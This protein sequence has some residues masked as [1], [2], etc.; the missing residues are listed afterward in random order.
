MKNVTLFFL[1]LLL[2]IMPGWNTV[3]AQTIADTLVMNNENVLVGEIKEMTHGVLQMKTKYSDSDLKLKWDHIKQ[4]HT[5][6]FFII[7][8][9]KGIH[10]Y[11]TLNTKKN[12]PGKIYLFDFQKGEALVPQGKIIYLKEA[13]QTFISRLSLDISLGYSLAKANNTSQFITRVNSGYLANVY[14]VR[15]NYSMNRNFQTVDDTLKTKIRRTEANFAGKYFLKKSWFLTGSANLLSSTEQKLNLRTTTLFGVGNFLINDHVHY[16]SISGGGVWNIERY[17][18]NDQPDKNSLEAF[19]NIEYVLF[20][21]GDL[22]IN[23]NLDIY[24][25]ITEKGRLRS[26]FNLNMKYKFIADF[27]INLGFTYNFDNQPVAGAPKWDYLF[28]TTI[29]WEL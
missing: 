28:E 20:N 3:S 26:D 27:F 5:Q 8:L 25:G 12:Q 11:G 17:S 21:F 10:Y 14:S 13:D 19:F 2:F 23:T 4:I 22:N 24:P 15:I 7:Y 16:L 18:E 29:G 6:R 1:L 9:E